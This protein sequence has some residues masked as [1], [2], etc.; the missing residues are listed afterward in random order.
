MKAGSLTLSF[1]SGTLAL[2]GLGLNTTK[3]NAQTTF[4]FEA[5][6][7]IEVTLKEIAPQIQEV[8]VIGESEDA[9][10]GLTN[11]TSMNYA[12]LDSQTGASQ[13][14]P[15]ATEFGLQGLPILTD[16]L[17][18]SGNDKLTGTSSATASLDFE[19]GLGIANGTLT[20]TDGEGRFQNATGTLSISDTYALSPDPTAPL[21]GEAIVSGS[22]TIP[23]TVPEAENTSTLIGIGIIGTG[24]LVR[25]RRKKIAKI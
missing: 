4:P 23:Q 12:F 6:Y 10:Y 20:I 18:G 19:N 21:I 16:T 15:D 7:D 22:F 8:T 13:S 3:A 14:G 5:T 9:P 17:F 1:I 24:L 25:Q 11:L 2:L